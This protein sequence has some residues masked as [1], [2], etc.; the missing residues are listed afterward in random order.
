M[1]SRSAEALKEA[2]EARAR[3]DRTLAE[4][5]RRIPSMR[6]ARTVVALVAAGGVATAIV[7]RLLRRSRRRGAPTAAPQAV[8]V[9]VVPWPAAVLAAAAWAG[10]RLYEL[11]TRQAAVRRF[12]RSA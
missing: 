7:W 11:R 6:A 3:L 1:G 8:N 10:V 9:T 5:E 2:E 12:P 4:L